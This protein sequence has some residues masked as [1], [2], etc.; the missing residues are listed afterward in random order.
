V[1]EI[2]NRL[3][4]NR[5]KDQVMQMFRNDGHDGG[6]SD[7]VRDNALPLAMI[8]LGL[9]WL[10]WSA[11]SGG[12]SSPAGRS[13]GRL[14]RARDWT[15]E[16]IDEA[17]R[18]MQH[19]G[20]SLR[21]RAEE[22][23][24]SLASGDTLPDRRRTAYGDP[25]AGAGSPAGGYGQDHSGEYHYRPAGRFM[26]G[27][28]G[29]DDRE[30]QYGEQMR[31]YGRAASRQAKE[32]YESFWQLV[33]DHPMLAGMMG[34]AAGAAL[35]AML[36]SSRYE[37]EWLGE[38]SDTMWDRGRHYGQDF[39]ERAGEVARH[40]T[41]AGYEAARDTVTEE[42]PGLVGEQERE[43]AGQRPQEH[44]RNRGMTGN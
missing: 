30:R 32:G 18:R 17:R 27:S 14:D 3:A 25:Y 21:R 4:P 36:P 7:T 37:D 44:E 5:L 40:A 2:Q 12:G 15:G 19:A 13:S 33:D 31:Q 38:Y 11:T 41:E 9:G 39:A 22:M 29:H 10:M 23:R 16:R 6:M 26:E 43:N 8:G 34:F 20:E 24:G 35:G 42:A 1:A 28:G